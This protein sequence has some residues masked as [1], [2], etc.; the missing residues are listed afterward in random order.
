M[1]VGGGDRLRA[2]VEAQVAV[3]IARRGLEAIRRPAGDGRNGSCGT[4][5][6]VR[7]R[8]SLERGPRTALISTTSRWI[9]SR[10]R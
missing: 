2:V 7:G 3:A 5:W 1:K 8:L 4:R 10:S 9:R 6:P